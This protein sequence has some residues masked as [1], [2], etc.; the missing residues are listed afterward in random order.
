[1]KVGYRSLFTPHPPPLRVSFRLL[2]PGEEKESVK[3]LKSPQ[4]KR[5]DQSILLFLVKLAFRVR[6]SVY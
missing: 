1:M 3:P 2:V 5:L 6:A 4:P